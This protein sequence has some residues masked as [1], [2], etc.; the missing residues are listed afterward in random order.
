METPKQ[1]EFT[2]DLKELNAK[3]EKIKDKFLELKDFDG[4]KQFTEFF[5]IELSNYFTSLS[6][7]LSLQT[8]AKLEYDEKSKSE[9][10]AVINKLSQGKE[11]SE[12]KPYINA[13]LEAATGA[14][15]VVESKKANLQGITLNS[16]KKLSDAYEF[17][18]DDIIKPLKSPINEL[19]EA[20]EKAS[21][22]K[23]KSP[24]A[25]LKSKNVQKE[26]SDAANKL[27]NIWENTERLYELYYKTQKN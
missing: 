8:K 13:I 25:V 9:G 2:K 11:K 1:K 26:L 16:F 12:S 6:I 14:L 19:I 7:I 27:E 20:F 23:V 5:I 18:F 10:L 22:A 3:L 17:I 15:K 24:F 4:S 21:N